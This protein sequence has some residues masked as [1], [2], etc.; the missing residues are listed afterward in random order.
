MRAMRTSSPSTKILKRL[1]SSED[2][3]PVAL[4]NEQC[5]CNDSTR[6]SSIQSSEYEAA[7]VREQ[8][9]R[10]YFEILHDFNKELSIVFARS[11]CVFD[12]RFVR[13][14]FTFGTLAYLH[15][16][17]IGSSTDVDLSAI[18]SLFSSIFSGNFDTIS[19]GSVEGDATNKL[20]P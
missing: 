20:W 1:L 11:N 13:D 4:C 17:F 9:S 10:G 16:I 2:E 18:S 5:F 6:L 15:A 3:S 7:I 19:D 8:L 12:R 14:E